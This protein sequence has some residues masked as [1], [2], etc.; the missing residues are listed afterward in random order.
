[1]SSLYHTHADYQ[2]YIKGLGYLMAYRVDEPYFRY[3]PHFHIVMPESGRNVEICFKENRYANPNSKDRL[4]KEECEILNNWMKTICEDYFGMIPWDPVTCTYWAGVRDSLH[5]PDRAW[6]DERW[7][8]QPDY[9][10]IEEPRPI[11]EDRRPFEIPNHVNPNVSERR[12]QPEIKGVGQIISYELED[13]RL[14]NRPHFHIHTDDGR[15]VQI[16]MLTNKYSDPE[17]KDRLTPEEVVLFNKWMSWNWNSCAGFWEMDYCDNR[18]TIGRYMLDNPSV[19]DYS[20]IF[21]PDPIEPYYGTNCGVIE[22]NNIDGVG[23]I[24]MVR[25]DY[26]KLYSYIPHFVIQSARGIIPIGLFSS[27]YLDPTAPTL[28]KYERE[29][30]YDILSFK[31]EMTDGSSISTWDYMVETWNHMRYS[32]SCAKHKMPNYKNIR[33]HKIANKDL[34]Y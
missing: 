30:L 15:N 9:S 14:L 25:N 4:T 10:T 7:D 3:R 17:S 20:T 28:S 33:M 19:L 6:I 8:I 21:E 1:M 12:F 2:E 24:L 26:S 23:R 31:R 11:E 27:V 18:I 22:I 32:T 16:C 29:D 34:K 13:V 5:I